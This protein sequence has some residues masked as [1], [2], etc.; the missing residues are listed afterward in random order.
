MTKFAQKK[1][2]NCD[3]IFQKGIFLGDIIPDILEIFYVW[4]HCL[5]MCYLSTKKYIS[6]TEIFLLTWNIFPY[7]P[8]CSEWVVDT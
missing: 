7:F 3:K 5:K 1:H 6:I 4:Q 8:R 2:I